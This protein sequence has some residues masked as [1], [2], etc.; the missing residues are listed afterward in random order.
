MIKCPNCSAEL[1]FSAKKQK[2]I[3]EYCGSE[4][5]AKTLK[6][7]VKMSKEVNEPKAVKETKEEKKKIVKE[8]EGKSFLCS[9]CGAKLM[10][11]DDTAVTFCSYCGSQ[12]VLEEEL[13]GKISPEL[14]IPFKITKEQ[15]IE[16]YKRKVKSSIFAPKYLTDSDILDKFRG[17]YMPYA[18]YKVGCHKNV[19]NKGSVYYK[20]I[21]NYM[22]Y[23]DYNVKADVDAEYDGISYDLVSKYYDVY[24]QAVR[25]NVKDAED[26]NINYLSGF[27]VDTKDVD[28]KTYY[29][30]AVDEVTGDANSRL[31]KQPIFAKHGVTSAKVGLDVLGVRKAL[32]PVYFMSF[33]DKD[34]EHIHYAVVN[35]QTGE[36]TFEIPV[37][38]P[39]FLILSAI[40]ILP[41][42]ILLEI[43]TYAL[44]PRL[45]LAFIV[46]T[47]I[48]TAIVANIKLNRLH[49]QENFLEDKGISSVT[50]PTK[51]KAKK[52]KYLI[53]QIITIGVC[54][55]GFVIYTIE[56]FFYYGLA[57]FGFV[58]MTLTFIDL[59]KLHN[60]L[61]KRKIPQL[62]KRGGLKQ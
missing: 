17:I 14:I 38:I 25:H 42:F 60:E 48:I 6:E 53:K 33:R 43:F 51:T 35:A 34:N 12:A 20:S 11:F 28:E 47:S 61:C 59:L 41:I 40:L 2:V 36:V 39:K 4:F 15:C 44:P 30:D 54:S 10:T 22:Y 56:D 58:M 32:F 7:Q 57:I 29:K 18:V 26:F 49:K 19:S 5:D 55:L 62:E 21:G 8:Y 23:H 27:Y 16:N 52:M 1:K 31:R 37:S 45:S 24:S 3:C 13:M 50:G 9:Q 46:V